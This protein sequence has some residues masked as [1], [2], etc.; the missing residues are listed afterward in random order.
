MTGGCLIAF[1]NKF[2]NVPII[3]MTAFNDNSRVNSFS[4][5]AVVPSLSP[6]SFYNH[7]PTTF[8]GRIFNF[9]LHMADKIS[10]HCYA[11]PKLTAIIQESTSFRDS[12][13]MLELGTKSV[14]YMINYVPSVDGMQQIPPNIIPVGGLQ[15]KP[16]KKL[17]EVCRI[18][19]PDNINTMNEMDELII[20]SRTFNHSLM[21]PKMDLSFFR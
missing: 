15:I 5:H 20:N 17:P 1:A 2:K 10:V 8:L 19:A 11:I 9:A 12:P 18:S 6:Y 16:P 21:V 13:S 3:G 7:N 4:K 14:L